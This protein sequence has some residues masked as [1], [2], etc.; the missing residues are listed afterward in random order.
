MTWR[1]SREAEED[2]IGIWLEGFETFG[3]AQ[4][5]KYQDGLGAAFALLAEFPELARERTEL[6]PPLRV[7]PFGSHLILYLIRPAGS[8]FVV[9]VRHKREDWI[10]EPL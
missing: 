9:R 4:A 10:S 1:L 8:V 7:H 3:P 2:L 5:D 6:T